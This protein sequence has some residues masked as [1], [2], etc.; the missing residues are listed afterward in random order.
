MKRCLPLAL[1]IA[2]LSCLA[3][4]QGKVYPNRWVYVSRSLSS[5][6]DVEDIREIARTAAEHGLNGIAFAGGLDRLDLQPPAYFDRLRQVKQICDDYQ[7]DLIPEFFSVGYGSSIISHNRNLAEGIPVKDA[8]FVAAKGEARLFPDPPVA[9]VNG[10]LEEYEGNR[11]QGWRFHDQPGEVSFV[12]TA[13]FKEGAASL[14]FENFTLNAYG[15]GRL[16][17]EVPVKPRRSYRVTCWVKTEALAP[18]G[19]FKLQVLAESGRALAPW[20]PQV[21]ASSDWRKLTLGFNSWDLDKVR[22]YAGVWGAQSGQFWLDDF[23]I[24]EVGLVN[25]VRRPGTPVTVR[26]EATDLVYEEGSDYAPIADPMLTFRF[27]HDGP[28]IRLLPG[29]RIQEG[30]RLRVDYYHGMSINQGQVTV[31]MSEPQVYEIWREQVRLVHQLLAPRKYFLS[32]DEIRAGGSCQACKRRMMSMAEILGDC[33]TRQLNLIREQNPEAE[34]YAWSDMLDPNHNAHDN[35]YLVDGDF[36][37]SW[38]YV[39]QDLGI[40]TWYY[41]KRRE[42]LAHFSSLGFRTLAG[43]YYDGDTLDN[44]KGWLEALDETPGACGIMYTTWENRYEL[45]APFGDLV[46]N[47]R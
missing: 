20:D 8:L 46:S 11:L 43:A 31:C 29:S 4:P 10:G 13:V 17:Q 30:E 2:A 9:F 16:M 15:H 38:W 44:P 7:L 33:L 6:R 1:L 47:P 45:L 14:R 3:W 5:D 23:R 37:G 24:E 39:P 36:T 21:P 28:P 19:V 34:V 12:D 32:M 40:V 26:S 22:I 42:S 25:V 35:Y 41:A 18:A 27:D